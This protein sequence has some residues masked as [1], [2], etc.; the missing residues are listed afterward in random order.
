MACA[1]V[2]TQRNKPGTKIKFVEQDADNNSSIL[3][4]LFD[5]RTTGEN[6]VKKY[7]YY[8]KN[9]FISQYA[10]IKDIDFTPI[11]EEVVSKEGEVQ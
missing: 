1:A 6:G 2:G 5:F 9:Y 11:F 4:N 3:Y 7:E 10:E 8:M